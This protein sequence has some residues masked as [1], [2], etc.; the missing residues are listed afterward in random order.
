MI[1]YLNG[2]Y[3]PRDQAMVSVDDRGFLF[4]DGIYE[5][6][7]VYQGYPF[8][9]DEHLKRLNDGLR[10]LSIQGVDTALFPDVCQRLL[11]ENDLTNSDGTL[12]IQVTRGAAPRLHAFP[13]E[14][15]PPTI[16]MATNV[17]KISSQVDDET[18]TVI[19]VPDV[20]WARCDI[21]SIS[22]I[23]NVLARQRAI[24]AGVREAIFVR[25]G[26]VMEGTASNLFA[27]FDGEVYTHPKTNYLLPG[28]TRD[29]VLSLCEETGI[30]V[31]AVP[32]LEQDMPEAQEIFVTSTTM[33][34][35]PVV[36]LDHRPVAKGTPGPITLKLKQAFQDRVA[37]FLKQRKQKQH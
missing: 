19:L 34:I 18:L 3:I 13:S 23:A 28:V 21:K 4:G 17:L 24:D 30:S 37:G 10:A 31:N 11:S 20:R 25:N 9:M 16:F 8:L 29:V 14:N 2:K 32:I 27:V 26:V 36:E 1:V 15:V 33:E 5:V 22:L 7:T 12:Y 6:V 35:V